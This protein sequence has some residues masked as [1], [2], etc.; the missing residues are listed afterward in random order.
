M[1]NERRL[2]DMYCSD[3]DNRQAIQM[4]FR[5]DGKICATDGHMMIRV[6]EKICEGEY[7]D[8]VNGLKPPTTSRVIPEPTIDVP[9]T[10][11]MINKALGKAPEDKDRRCPE[12]NGEGDVTWTYTDRLHNK[13]EMQAQCPECDGTGELYDYTA[14]KYQF[15]FL[16][17][18]LCYYHLKTLLKTMEILRADTLHC[19]YAQK[20]QAMLLT[21]DGVE[22]IAMPQIQ[23]DK[24]TQIKL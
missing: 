10:I 22:I 20:H 16:G 4:P 13:H 21:T 12:C 1:E 7:Y 18:C 6:D 24:L 11:K 14:V 19:R 15:N 2:F 5:Q 17:C 23:D 3:N 9:L 8:T